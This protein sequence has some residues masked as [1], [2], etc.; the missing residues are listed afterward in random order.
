VAPLGLAL[1]S[2]AAAFLTLSDVESPS[3]DRQWTVGDIDSALDLVSAF[4]LDIA[5]ATA[6]RWAP[7]PP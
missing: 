4:R 3:P 6:D 7:P 2:C 5:E 1:L